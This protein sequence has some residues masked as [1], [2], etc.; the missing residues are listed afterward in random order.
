MRPSTLPL[1]LA[2]FLIGVIVGT[3]QGTWHLGWFTICLIG[4]VFLHFAANLVNEWFDFVSGADALA[5]KLPD[6]YITTPGDIGSLIR[7]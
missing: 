6:N 5:I 1:I 4:V 3:K 2:P 7:T